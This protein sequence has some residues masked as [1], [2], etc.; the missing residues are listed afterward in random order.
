MRLLL[1]IKT[2]NRLHF[3]HDCL[4]SFL[5]TRDHDLNW[6]VVI[7]DDGSQDGTLEYIRELSVS[8]PL[9]L[10]PNKRIYACGQTNT[11]M[12]FFIKGKYDL[13]FVVDDDLYFRKS[14]W[15]RLYRS[16]IENTGYSHLCYYNQAFARES[17]KECM[18]EFSLVNGVSFESYGSVSNAMGCLFT[19]DKKLID[20]I[21][22]I[23][24]ENFPV[25]GFWH[26][27]FSARCCRAGLNDK[28]E[29]KDVAGSNEYIGL[30]NHADAYYLSQKKSDISRNKVRNIKEDK[31]RRNV[32]DDA[33]RL[34]VDR[35][36]RNI[37]VE[38]ICPE[39][40]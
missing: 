20:T 1:G 40:R 4:I 16:A 7:A 25:H 26:I 32:I 8:V 3:L 18:P 23:D 2:L 13:C 33:R 38:T 39:K 24:E 19:F 27:D 28:S 12:D 9:F 22:Y 35:V 29:F 10:M 14:G 15:D 17:G 5:N 36:N 34:Y 11:I 31:R 6:S 21:G 37:N 30:Q